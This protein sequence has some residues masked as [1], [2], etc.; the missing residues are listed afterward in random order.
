MNLE[1]NINCTT[2]SKIRSYI[3]QPI[4]D[5]ENPSQIKDLLSEEMNSRKLKNVNNLLKLLKDLE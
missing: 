1:D 2:I 5:N 4:S 3:R